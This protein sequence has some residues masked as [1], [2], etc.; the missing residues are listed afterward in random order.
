[1]CAITGKLWSATDKGMA[2]NAELSDTTGCSRKNCTK[3]KAHNFATMGHQ[4]M[5]FS[6]KCLE[7][8]W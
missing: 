1:M 7:I 4:I 2:G 8:N 3:F 6:P 5:C